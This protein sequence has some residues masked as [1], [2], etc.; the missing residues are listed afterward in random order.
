MSTLNKEIC[1]V[2]TYHGGKTAFTKEIMDK[3]IANFIPIKG[4]W[5]GLCAGHEGSDDPY[6]TLGRVTKLWSDDGI[7][8]MGE[9]EIEKDEDVVLI[10]SVSV[11]GDENNIDHVAVVPN[12]AVRDLKE[13]PIAA[14]SKN[15]CTIKLNINDLD[16]PMNF[17]ELKDLNLNLNESNW[18]AEI[19]KAFIELKSKYEVKAMAPELVDAK[20]ELWNIKFNGLKS[21]GKITPAQLSNINEFYLNKN[22]I[23][24]NLRDNEKNVV[25]LYE[26]MTLN[27][28]V[29]FGEKTGVQAKVLPD[30]NKIE[31]KSAHDIATEARKKRGLKE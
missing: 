27:K 26:L 14:A 13:Y 2:G 6:K 10:N 22:N 23:E 24:L 29:E 5:C 4:G 19:K 17:D 9:L 30:Q 18:Q 11:A 31:E 3:W 1:K 20:M 28:G 21:E 16:K 7:T 8:L 15:V 12:P 25:K